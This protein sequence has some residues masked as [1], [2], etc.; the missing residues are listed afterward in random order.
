MRFGPNEFTG[1]KTAELVE[2]EIISSGIFQPILLQI[3]FDEK[4]REEEY[5]NK[6]LMNNDTVVTSETGR[7]SVD[8]QFENLIAANSKK[9][10]FNLVIDKGSTVGAQ[11]LEYCRTLSPLHPRLP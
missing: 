3:A 4:F 10:L 5:D 6:E 7:V 11:L 1:S 2:T 8:V 9:S